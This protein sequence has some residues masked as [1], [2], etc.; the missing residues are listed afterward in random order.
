MPL[1]EISLARINWGAGILLRDGHVLTCH[2]VVPDRQSVELTFPFLPKVSKL[3]PG[4]IVASVTNC[5][6]RVD[7][8][9]RRQRQPSDIAVLTLPER[10]RDIIAG[11]KWGIQPSDTMWVADVAGRS[12]TAYG[13]PAGYPLGTLAKVETAF[14]D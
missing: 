4:P 3:Y 7:P 8:E 6:P 2:H 5:F 9:E 10:L 13:F 14:R 11:E 1:H 12:F